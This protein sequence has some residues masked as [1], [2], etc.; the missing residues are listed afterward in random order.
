MMDRPRAAVVISEYWAAV[1][2]LLSAAAIMLPVIGAGVRLVRYTFAG[3]PAEVAL[4]ESIPEHVVQGVLALSS[5][6]G[7]VIVAG[8]FTAMS[9]F[10]PPARQPKR[11]PRVGPVDI[12]AAVAS[13]LLIDNL[14][15]EAP[16]PAAV[17][18][19]IAAMPLGFWMGTLAGQG[20]R[21]SIA[22]GVRIAIVFAAISIVTAG[23]AP[24]GVELVRI[25]AAGS[26]NLEGLFAE[27]GH[28]DRGIY[29]RSCTN[30]D[31]LFAGFERVSTIHYVGKT[32]PRNGVSFAQWLSGRQPAIGTILRCD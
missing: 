13:G 17:L 27:L 3:L 24:A 16:F 28:N 31:T 9:F 8:Y 32:S 30:G 29:L 19:G 15:F 2:G 11:G 23:L 14:L 22:A 18:S 1:G 12:T 25:E 20:R 26:T 21:M 10:A 5:L 4:A 6:L 7:L